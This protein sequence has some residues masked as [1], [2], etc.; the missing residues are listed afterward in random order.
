MNCATGRGGVNGGGTSEGDA[1]RK[2]MTGEKMLAV[3]FMDFLARHGLSGE[4]EM[5]EIGKRGRDGRFGW[6]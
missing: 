6:K 4:S 3:I 1:L 2:E 5:G